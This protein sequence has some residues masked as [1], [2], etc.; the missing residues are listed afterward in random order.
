[1]LDYKQF[2]SRLE[3]RNPEKQL[4]NSAANINVTLAFNYNS[5]TQGKQQINN[6]RFWLI[7]TK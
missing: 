7:V 3:R 6:D 1:M 5:N 2:N 4:A